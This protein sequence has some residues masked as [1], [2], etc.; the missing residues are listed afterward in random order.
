MIAPS[1]FDT[2]IVA[3]TGW[4][5]PVG[6]YIALMFPAFLL[7]LTVMGRAGRTT[8]VSNLLSCG[9][10]GHLAREVGQKRLLGTSV[11]RRQCAELC[12]FHF[13]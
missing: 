7:C 8:T 6:E 2:D 11:G 1:G 10:C 9:T 13:F 12:A 5:T 4:G 3:S